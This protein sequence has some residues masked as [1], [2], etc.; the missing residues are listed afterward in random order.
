MHGYSKHRC[1]LLKQ[2][3]VMGWRGHLKAC[4]NNTGDLL[5]LLNHYDNFGM[6]RTHRRRDFRI[7]AVDE[8]DVFPLSVSA[9]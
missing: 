1:V 7:R 6:P 3:A 2:L 4:E 9:A 5:T 8:R